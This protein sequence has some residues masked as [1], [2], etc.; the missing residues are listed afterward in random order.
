MAIGSYRHVV[1]VQL[2]AGS[3]VPNGDG[4]FSDPWID[5]KPAIWHCSIDEAAGPQERP[6]AGSTIAT[7]ARVVRG[8]YRADITVRA[9]LL[10]GGSRVL[11][12]VGVGTP[13]D[14]GIDLELACVEVQPS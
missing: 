12:V 14:R 5:A 1:R 9:R 7:A 2:P 13:Q 10:V 11:S 3:P 8:R 4:G 6:V